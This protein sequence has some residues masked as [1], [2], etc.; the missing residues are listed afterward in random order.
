MALRLEL[1]DEEIDE[2]ALCAEAMSIPVRQ[3]HRHHYPQDAHFL[4]REVWDLKNTPPEKRPLLLHYHPLVIYRFQVLKQADVVLAL[5]LQ[6]DHCTHEQKRDNFEYYDPITTGGSTLSGVVQ[7]I[8]AAEVGYHDLRCATSTTRCSSIWRICTA[9]P[10]TGSTWPRQ[11][12]CGTSWLTDSAVCGTTTTVRSPS[13]PACPRSW[14]G[15]TF[16]SPWRHPVKVDLTSKEITFTVVE[17]DLAELSVRDEHFTVTA[18]RPLACHWLTRARASRVRYR[19][20]PS[21]AG[22]MGHGSRRRYR[23]Q[24]FWAAEHVSRYPEQ[25][26]APG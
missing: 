7:S 26:L 10:A 2:W 5:F 19:P 12:A 24:S 1:A 8:I 11:V 6:G 16:R 22:R 20:R 3:G 9:T 13:V 17:G 4:D 14:P 25:M 15:L 21:T 23:R 18:G